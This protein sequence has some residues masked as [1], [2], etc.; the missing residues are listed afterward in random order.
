[1]ISVR[2]HTIEYANSDLPES[3]VFED[4]NPQ[5]RIPIAFIVYCIQTEGR[6]IL[7]DA[8]C[9]TMPGFDMHDFIG[10]VNALLQNG[11]SPD[12]VT[13]VILTHSHHDHAEAVA[14]FG[15]ATVHVQ[16]EEYE[17]AKR[18]IPASM[19]VKLFDDSL[20]LTDQI[21]VQCVGGHSRGSSV[22]KIHDNGQ[23]LLIVGD[24]CYSRE[25]FLQNRLTGAS[26]FPEKSR[27]FLNEHRTSPYTLLFCHDR[28]PLLVEEK[29]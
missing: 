10:P 3:M 1:V 16:R 24:E 7:V 14:H 13:D 22:V 27:A 9:D 28:V 20:S 6:T 5:K 17:K 23:K 18:Y 26:R 12:A 19:R 25:C 2:F 21:T 11:I 15:N 29:G 8:G 4:G